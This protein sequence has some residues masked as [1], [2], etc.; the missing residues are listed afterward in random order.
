M[1]RAEALPPHVFDIVNRMPEPLSPDWNRI[2][3][4]DRHL[5]S[6]GWSHG[7]VK[8]FQV[9]F[10]GDGLF[11]HFAY[12]P[13]EEGVLA[14]CELGPGREEQQISYA[15]TGRLVS[16]R[17]KY[18][19]PGD[20]NAHF[21]Q[22]GRIRA[23]VRNNALAIAEPEASGHLF[24]VDVQGLEH[25][26]EMEGERYYSGEY[27]RAMFEAPRD[28][29]PDCVHFT[30]FWARPD[31]EARARMRNPVRT[32][33]AGEHEEDRI[34]LSP[35]PDSPL[36]GGLLLVN[37]TPREPLDN[38][39]DHMV[40]FTGGFAPEMTDLEVGGGFLMMSYPADQVH[41]FPSIDY[42][43]SRAG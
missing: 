1:R 21:S 19:H 9:Q 27:G 35:L 22:D 41:D 15:E 12:H 7:W 29:P 42:L 26:R 5:V 14:R 33:I 38:S 36:Y 18:S 32:R 39:K 28:H 30:G 20:G 31:P 2:D 40:L 10:H 34:A 43:G 8:V 3:E 17:V 11:V 6:F 37:A 16:S 4:L 23:Q 13:S 24:S 25:F